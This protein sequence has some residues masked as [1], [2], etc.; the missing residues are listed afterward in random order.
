VL[1]D[2]NLTLE[3][4]KKNYLG[5]VPTKKPIIKPF[6]SHLVKSIHK[7]TPRLKVAEGH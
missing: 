6:N 5:F 1:K 7:L 2:K 3:T 4:F